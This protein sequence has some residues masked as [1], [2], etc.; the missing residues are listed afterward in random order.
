MYYANFDSIGLIKNLKVFTCDLHLKT[1]YSI[2]LSLFTVFF[3]RQE[4]DTV[5]IF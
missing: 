1:F 2:C 3:S 4:V 5:A